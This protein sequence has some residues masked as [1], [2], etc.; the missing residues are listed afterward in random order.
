MWK[1]AKAVQR[2]NFIVINAYIKK[3]ER[4]QISNLTL[5]LK[6]P[7]KEERTKSKLKMEGNKDQRRMNQIEDRKMI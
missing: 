1:V 3:E 5:Y 7:E 4:H 2:G 6:V